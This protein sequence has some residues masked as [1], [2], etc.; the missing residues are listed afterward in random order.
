MA[1]AGFRIVLHGDV[2]EERDEVLGYLDPERCIH[3]VGG[4]TFGARAAD[5]P[6]STPRLYSLLEVARDLKQVRVIRRAQRTAEG[7]YDEYAVYGPRGG[8]KG[9]YTISLESEAG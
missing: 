1:A 5:R 8:K 3:A 6:E 9:E 2:H 7:A 4:G